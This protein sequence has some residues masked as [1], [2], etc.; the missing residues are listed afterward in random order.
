[1]DKSWMTIKN[2]MSKEYRDGVNYFVDFAVTSSG[3]DDKIRCPC[4]KCMNVER[5]V[6]VVVVFHLIQNGIAPSYKTWVHNGEPIPANH[7]FVLN[8]SCQPSGESAGDGV[9]ANEH[10]NPDDIER[11]VNDY[12]AAAIM[13]DEELDELPDNVETEKKRVDDGVLRHPVDG[14]PWKDFDRQYPEFARDARNVRLGLATDGFNPF[15]NMSN[16]YSLWPVILMP[17]NLPPWKCIKQHYSMMSLLIPRPIA[18]GGDIDVYLRPLLDELKELWE[19]GATT[20][21]ASAE[22]TF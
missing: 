11:S 20:Y 18:P 1:M 22:Q 5:H 12:Y 10:E 16:S 4:L 9:A 13:N 15:G 6:S 2:R 14:E 8:E 7:Q 3:S 21:D 17:Y 19:H